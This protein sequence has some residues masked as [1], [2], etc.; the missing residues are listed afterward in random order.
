MLIHLWSD[1]DPKR[2]D[3]WVESSGAAPDET[4]NAVAIVMGLDRRAARKLVESGA[5][6]ATNVPQTRVHLLNARFTNWGVRLRVEPEFPWPLDRPL[7]MDVL[8]SKLEHSAQGRFERSVVQALAGLLFGGI[9]TLVAAIGL[10]PFAVVVVPV[11][12]SCCVGF[13][14]G[15]G[16]R[17]L[18]A[19]E[20]GIPGLFA[21]VLVL[22][23]LEFCGFGVIDRCFNDDDSSLPISLLY[24]LLLIAACAAVACPLAAWIARRGSRIEERVVSPKADHDEYFGCRRDQSG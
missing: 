12:V 9:V 5:P 8:N 11:V 13:A 2:F 15:G 21:L 4:A 19:A 24:D 6:V 10:T 20:R 3:V 16:L 18:V 17:G 1:G 22:L 7:P 23:S 14:W